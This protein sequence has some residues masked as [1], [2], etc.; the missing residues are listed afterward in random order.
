MADYL[1][2]EIIDGNLDYKEVVTRKPKQK[3]GIDIYLKA[4]GREDL[5]V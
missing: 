5:I 2:Q 1:A 3:A 4:Q